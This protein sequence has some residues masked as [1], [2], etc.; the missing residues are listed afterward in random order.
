M[1]ANTRILAWFVQHMKFSTLKRRVVFSLAAIVLLCVILITSVSYHAIRKIQENNMKTTLLFDLDQQSNKLTENFTNLLLITQQLT[2]QGTVGRLVEGY[3]HAGDPYSRSVLSRDISSSMGE[4]IFSHPNI[5]L[6]MFI[7]SKDNRIM[8]NN[9][10]LRDGFT[11]DSLPV[12]AA[13]SDIAYQPPH[14]SL[15]RFSRDQVISVTREI[16][17]SDNERW[18]VYVEA[19]TN[20]SSDISLLSGSVAM[21]YV[22]TL[23][24]RKNL[25]RFSSDEKTFLPGQT[26]PMDDLSVYDKE[27]KWNTLDSD[28]GYSVTLWVKSAGYDREVNTWRNFLIIILALILPATVL[29]AVLLIQVIY[30]P[31]HAFEREMVELGN[32]NLQ[33]MDY[34]WGIK[35]FD[36]LFAQFNNMKQRI[37][38]LLVDVTFM[39]KQKHQMEV[40]MLSYQI[41]PHFLMNAL[42]SVHWLAQLHNQP[43]I[44]KVICTLNLLLAYNLGKTPEKATLRSEIKILTAYLELQQ[45]RYDFNIVWKI[46]EGDYL[47]DPVASFI[48]QPI[49]EN[50]LNHG[51]DED[52][53]LEVGIG[54]DEDAGCILIW[55]QDDGKGMDP[56]TLE[57]VRITSALGSTGSAGGIG[58]RYVRSV[59]ESYY[60]EKASLAIDSA[61]HK[62]T[63]VSMRFPQY[64]GRLH[65]PRIDR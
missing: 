2:P 18:M 55:I 11:S 49:A 12:L 39:E 1:L 38:Q 64:E 21:P 45:M 27:F 29:I 31:L 42:N 19:R 48:L 5:E 34:H 40:E 14:I 56:D 41:N 25:V 3:L 43:E 13:Y 61:H 23:T 9:L 24:D 7:N 17:F 63:R 60:G 53:T 10:P 20:I 57:K 36:V 26:L 28:Y 50:A 8:F 51:L 4:I 6:V 37:Q 52:G 15:C 30:K 33:H 62:G 22:L 32:G 54:H 16:T 35:E 46:E 58:L 47:D 59:L 65:D 44:D